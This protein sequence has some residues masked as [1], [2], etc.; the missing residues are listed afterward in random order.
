MKPTKPLLAFAVALLIVLSCACP[1]SYQETRTTVIVKTVEFIS[2]LTVQILVGPSYGSGVLISHLGHTYVMSCHH[3][4]ADDPHQPLEIVMHDGTS[5]E[6]F[7]KYGN[8]EYDLCLIDVPDLPINHRT[9]KISYDDLFIGEQVIILGYPVNKGFSV[10]VGVVSGTAKDAR[11]QDFLF[12]GFKEFSDLVLTDAALN[13][14]NSGGPVVDITG[15]LIGIAQ[16]TNMRYDGIGLFISSN[17][18]KE[19]LDGADH[20]RLDLDLL[21]QGCGLSK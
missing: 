12:G 19:F 11:I 20:E 15:R 17:I 6:G 10:S 9:I 18:I 2:P 14:G 7:Y 1:P 8:S 13:P 16:L 5:Y 4:V 21:R 3:V